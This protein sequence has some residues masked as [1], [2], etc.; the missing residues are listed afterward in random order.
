MIGEPAF[1]GLENWLDTNLGRSLLVAGGV[2]DLEAIKRTLKSQLTLP[3]SFMEW[4]SHAGNVSMMVA[5]TWPNATVSRL[6]W[7]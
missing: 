3:F 7:R 4:G 6:L 2:N 5:Q 1:F